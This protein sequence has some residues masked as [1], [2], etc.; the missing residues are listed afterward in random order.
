[1]RQLQYGDAKEDQPDAEKAGG[2][3]NVAVE[4]NAVEKCPR[5]AYPRPHRVGGAD[6]DFLLRE[7]EQQAAGEHKRE[8]DDHAH[9]ALAFRLRHLQ[10]DGPANLHEASERQVDPGH[11]QFPFPEGGEAARDAVRQTAYCA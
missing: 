8:R 11:F 5:R 9:E 6:G 3:G 4:Q 10:A 7:P 1:M 2:A